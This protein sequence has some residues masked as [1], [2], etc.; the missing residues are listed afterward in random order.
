MKEIV[1]A[2]IR[3]IADVHDHLLTIN[4]AYEARF[5]DKDLHFLVFGIAGTMV[6]LCSW[7]LFKWLRRHLGVAAW[8]FSFVV[9][10]MLALS[11]EVG[12]GLTQTGTM[13]IG[14]IAAGMIGFSAFSLVAGIVF[15]SIGMI[16]KYLRRSR[17]NRRPR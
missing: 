13:E 5:S 9:M 7:L 3:L 14:D 10:L 17:K 8:L 6:F 11:I 15:G 16:M 1:Y 4:D 2:F 12:Q